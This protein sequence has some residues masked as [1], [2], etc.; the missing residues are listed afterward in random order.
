MNRRIL[1]LLLLCAGLATANAASADAGHALSMWQVAGQ[2][3]RVYLLGSIH[4]L[5]RQDHPLPSAIYDAYDG[6]AYLDEPAE[7]SDSNAETTAAAS[8]PTSE[9]GTLGGVNVQGRA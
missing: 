6:P 2:H 1:N 5:R 8:A 9:N 3:N 7:E 4:L